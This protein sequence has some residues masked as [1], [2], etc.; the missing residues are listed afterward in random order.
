MSSR[1]SDLVAQ[2][3][4]ANTEGGETDTDCAK[5]TLVSLLKADG[6]HEERAYGDLATAEI[7]RATRR[8]MKAFARTPAEQYLLPYRLHERYALDLP[9]PDGE[10]ARR[11]INTYD[12]TQMQA[13]QAL[14]VRRQQIEADKRSADDLER[15]I[16][17]A[18]PYWDRVPSLTF[19]QALELA[20]AQQVAA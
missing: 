6:S 9:G 11:I 18:E 1:L 3:I 2:A 8:L 10:P 14:K 12:M 17:A 19:G 13:E 7:A 5:Q 4:E 15:A 16:L 20:A